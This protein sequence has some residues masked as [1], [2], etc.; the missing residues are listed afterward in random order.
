MHRLSRSHTR[1]RGYK[2]WVQSQ[3]QNKAQWFAAWGHL[4]ASSQSLCFNL[5]LRMNSSFITSRPDLQVI[6]SWGSTV[7]SLHSRQS[8]LVNFFHVILGL[9]G[10]HLLSTCVS[11]AVRMLHMSKPSKP[12]LSQNEVRV[13]KIKLYHYVIISD[14]IIK[15]CS[16]PWSLFSQNRI[17]SSYS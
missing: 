10:P 13:L 5:S 14:S 6:F 2:I 8:F 7:V 11:H 9:P 4:S 3:T 15:V 17:S 12:P 1:P 16:H